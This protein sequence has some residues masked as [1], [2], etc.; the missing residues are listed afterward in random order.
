MD[1]ETSDYIK[2]QATNLYSQNMVAAKIELIS[3]MEHL[4]NPDT[5]VNLRATLISR[6]EFILGRLNLARMSQAKQRQA[7]MMELLN[8]FTDL[9]KS[10]ISRLIDETINM[11]EIAYK[12]SIH[13]SATNEA[14]TE[15]A[16]AKAAASAAAALAMNPV[17]ISDT[18]EPIVKLEV[19]DP[20]P[21]ANYAKPLKSDMAI[22]LVYF[23]ACSYKNLER[24]LRMTLKTLEDAEIPV[25]LVEH[26]FKDQEPIFPENGTTVF[27][28][29]SDSYMFYKENLLNWLMPKVPAQY[30]KFYMMDCDLIFEK[31]TWYDDVSG[32]LDTHDVVQP[33]QEAIWL[34]S[35]LKTVNAKRLG[36]AYGH[37]LGYSL[38]LSDYH[39]GFVWAF[40]R[41]FIEPIGIF[42]LNVLGSGDTI[43]ASAAI[44]KNLLESFWKKCN[45]EANCNSSY[46]YIDLFNKVRTT[47]YPNQI[48]Y[49]LW[50]GSNKNRKYHVRYQ[51]LQ[52][53]CLK[54]NITTYK[55]IYELNTY[56]LYE[57]K[58]SMR[59]KFNKILLDYF[60][61]RDE[62]EI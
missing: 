43:L 22:L 4:N 10:D 47:Y 14:I 57:F 58:E 29:R 40:R 31:D 20:P 8:K 19:L 21:R 16:E 35:D 41:D 49:H 15:I 50:H 38:N 33:F 52:S 54:N 36:F 24:N 61:S 56:D 12:D 3:V 6:K 46:S 32:L 17:N 2:D 34:D 44:Q 51:L 45:I 11:L 5:D 9:Q 48:V 59:D 7:I 27:N 28:T 55:E 1:Q 42:D 23:N 26:L 25:F 37:S 18:V 62:D 30:T 53:Y 13:G 39:P 60:K